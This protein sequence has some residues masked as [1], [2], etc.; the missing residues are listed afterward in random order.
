MPP[1]VQSL[2][3]RESLDSV[4]Q[5]MVVHYLIT[6]EEGPTS[7][8]GLDRVPA[9]ST[10]GMCNQACAPGGWNGESRPE[11]LEQLD[12]ACSRRQ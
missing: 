9:G 8:P 10:H 12:M 11:L 3:R 7:N 4:L 1:P 5:I 2:F 6:Y